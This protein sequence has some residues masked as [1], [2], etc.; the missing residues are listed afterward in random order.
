MVMPSF[1]DLPTG[2]SASLVKGQAIFDP[3]ETVVHTEDLKNIGTENRLEQTNQVLQ[4]VGREMIALR[5]DMESYFG[6][7]GSTPNKIG[8]AVARSITSNLSNA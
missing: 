6:I 3:G 5:K 8:S 4:A 1:Q 7:H 2:Q